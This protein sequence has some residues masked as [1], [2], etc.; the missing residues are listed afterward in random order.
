MIGWVEIDIIIKY[1]KLYIVN[2][3][4]INER[5]RENSK[6]VKWLWHD[7]HNTQKM[8]YI[9]KAMNGS[10]SSVGDIKIADKSTV[11]P[12][13]SQ[14]LWFKLVKQN[15]HSLGSS[16][17]PSCVWQAEL[18]CNTSL[19]M[20][21]NIIM[22]RDMLFRSIDGGSN[23]MHQI[24]HHSLDLLSYSVKL[25]R[26]IGLYIFYKYCFDL[27]LHRQFIISEA[28]NK[29]MC[30]Y[31]EVPSWIYLSSSCLQLDP[32]HLLYQ[33]FLDQLLLSSEPDTSGFLFHALFLFFLS[34]NNFDLA[35][36]NSS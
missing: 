5:F 10:W 29:Y 25:K 18:I 30:G 15:I 27:C 34:T 1:S 9:W 26:K 2:K 20:K 35:L 17:H 23:S 22:F 36:K 21:T 24:N 16:S 8:V 33:V 32:S 6:T 14:D 31:P 3:C 12:S 13:R 4:V 28:Q 11:F 7:P 19:V